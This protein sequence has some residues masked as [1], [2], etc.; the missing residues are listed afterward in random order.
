[1]VTRSLFKK[2]ERKIKTLVTVIE[3][4]VNEKR[5]SSGMVSFSEQVISNR[6]TWDEW[7]KNEYWFEYNLNKL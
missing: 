6:V 4:Y 1:M 2:K 3:Y 5:L 7:R